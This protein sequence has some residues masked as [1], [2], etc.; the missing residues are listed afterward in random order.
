MHVEGTACPHDPGVAPG[1]RLAVAR[2][3]RGGRPLRDVST[4]RAGQVLAGAGGR[5]N[6]SYVTRLINEEA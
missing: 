6:V 3:G 2:R 1:C 4:R 5:R